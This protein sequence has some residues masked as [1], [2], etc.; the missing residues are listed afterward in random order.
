MISRRGRSPTL[1]ACPPGGRRSGLA[2]VELVL[3]LPVWIMIAA[4]MILIG[5]TGAWRVRA[6]TVARDAAFQQ[7]WPRQPVRPGRPAEWFPP[8]ATAGA[9][10]AASGL[11]LLDA[12]IGHSVMRGPVFA[13][14]QSTVMLTV[15]PLLAPNDAVVVGRARLNEPPAVWRSSGYRHRMERDFA[16]A[17]GETGQQTGSGSGL[18]ARRLWNIDDFLG[19][20][21]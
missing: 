18:Q 17:S 19:L 5:T 21:P 14:P 11:A 9:S 4:L 10:P 13:P 15:Q 12:T 7:V 16:V 8:S 6:Q 1:P 3:A 2:P 20:A